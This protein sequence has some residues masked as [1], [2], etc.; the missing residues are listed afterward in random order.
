LG[1]LRHPL[2]EEGRN[3]SNPLR[4]IETHQGEILLHARI[5]DN[6]ENPLRGIETKETTSKEQGANEKGRLKVS[7]KILF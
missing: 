6:E 5:R 7:L 1:P 4:G 2:D 3:E